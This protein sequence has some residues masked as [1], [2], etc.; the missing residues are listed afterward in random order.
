VKVTEESESEERWRTIFE[1]GERAKE[2][3]FSGGS[4]LRLV[5][6]RGGIRPRLYSVQLLYRNVRTFD[7]RVSVKGVRERRREQWR[8]Q[9]AVVRLRFLL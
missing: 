2:E 7:L 8:S 1:F 4:E 9:R 5:F 6:S 3:E